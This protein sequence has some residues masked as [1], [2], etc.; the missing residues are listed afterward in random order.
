M[1]SH[2]Y[3][4]HILTLVII[5]IKTKRFIWIHTII[6]VLLIIIKYGFIQLFMC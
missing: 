4:F 1:Q 2:D 5:I 6:Y 3:F